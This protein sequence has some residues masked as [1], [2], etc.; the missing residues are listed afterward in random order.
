MRRPIESANPCRLTETGLPTKEDVE[1]SP[2]TFAVDV[3]LGFHVDPLMIGLE[4]SLTLLPATG[5][6]SPS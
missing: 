2:Y 5:P 3:Q 6:C 1:M 4:L